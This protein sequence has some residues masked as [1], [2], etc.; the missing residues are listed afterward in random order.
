MLA[1]ESGCSLHIYMKNQNHA[2]CIHVYTCTLYVL[3][4]HSRES[5]IS[6][7]NI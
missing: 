4:S 6:R 3:A 5:I 7:N 2:V 1:E